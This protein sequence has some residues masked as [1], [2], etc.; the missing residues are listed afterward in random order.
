MDQLCDGERVDASPYVIEHDAGAAVEA[1]ELADW[2]RLED[3]EETK[4]Y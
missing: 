3:V 2:R 1:F 4:E